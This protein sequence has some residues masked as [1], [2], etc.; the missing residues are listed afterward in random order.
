MDILYF[1]GV[2]PFRLGEEEPSWT[3][4]TSKGYDP[5]GWGVVPIWTSFTSQG[6]EGTIMDI[7]Q[8]IVAGLPQTCMKVLQVLRLPRKTSRMGPKCCAC[9]ADRSGAQ[10]NQSSPNFRGPLWRCS[11]CCPC[12]AKRA[13]GAQ[14][15][16]I[17]GI[18]RCENDAFVRGFP[19]K[20]K[21]PSVT[22]TF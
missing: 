3:S 21:L 8:S 18:R 16:F 10:C 12:H 19:Q 15:S 2:R 13:W 6:Y 20:V 7:M 22:K 11:K 9:P 17:Y 4:F 14:T 5:L 1:Q